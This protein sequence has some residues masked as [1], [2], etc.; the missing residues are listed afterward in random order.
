MAARQG[1][2]Q[3][4]MVTL[5]YFKQDELDFEAFKRKKYVE[6]FNQGFGIIEMWI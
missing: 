6:A 2:K 5:N 3:R 4:K 1:L